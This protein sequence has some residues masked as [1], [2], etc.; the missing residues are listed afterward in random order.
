MVVPF[1]VVRWSALS[2]GRAGVWRED[3]DLPGGGAGLHGDVGLPDLIQ[4][5]YVRDR[6]DGVP[7]RDGVE[8]ALEDLGWQVGGSAGVC[9]EADAAWDVVDRVEVAN[10]PLVGQHS[11]EA[12]HAVYAGCR[13]GVRQ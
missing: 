4:L 8:K 5:V 11:G 2:A 7:S 1:V 12:H 6:D 10:H 9:G 3:D 13:E